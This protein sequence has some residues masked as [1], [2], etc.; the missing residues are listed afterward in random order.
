VEKRNVCRVLVGEPKGQLLLG[1]PTCGRD[2]STLMDLKETG[3]QGMDWIHWAQ[4][5]D[6]IGRL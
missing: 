6:T 5:R 2:E 1:R 3:W 4:N